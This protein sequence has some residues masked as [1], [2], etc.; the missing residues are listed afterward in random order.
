MRAAVIFGILGGWVG[1]LQLLILLCYSPPQP[2]P[3]GLCLE[4]GGIRPGAGEGQRSAGSGFEGDSVR[5]SAGE[6]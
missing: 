3:Q 1:V 5:L 2:H 4:M 6:E